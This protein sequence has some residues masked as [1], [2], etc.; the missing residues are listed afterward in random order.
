MQVERE[1]TDVRLNNMMVCQQSGELRLVEIFLAI[2]LACTQ[3]HIPWI[4]LRI[5][6]STLLVQQLGFWLPVEPAH[7]KGTVAVADNVLWPE[8]TLA[9]L[10]ADCLSL[11]ACSAL[12][13]A[14]SDAAHLFVTE[15]WIKVLLHALHQSGAVDVNH[16]V[17]AA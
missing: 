5:V 17:I 13:C 6:L 15:C 1:H 10:I 14:R 9:E 3:P 2:A 8:A 12:H 16:Y 7:I 4:H 11:E